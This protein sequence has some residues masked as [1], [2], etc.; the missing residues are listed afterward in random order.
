MKSVTLKLELIGCWV[1]FR[2]MNFN[3]II[4][5]S[6]KKP[7]VAE[8]IGLCDQYG[9][10][11]TFLSAMGDYSEALST[12]SR[13]V[14]FYYHLFPGKVYEIF[15]HCTWKRERRY[16]ATVVNGKIVDI[17]KNDIYKWLTNEGPELPFT[18]QQ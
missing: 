10:K 4:R 3:S 9:F 6:K 16:F 14:Y 8:I 5:T 11:R 15:E 18:M 7:W 2:G 1:R 17:E 13:G 12:K